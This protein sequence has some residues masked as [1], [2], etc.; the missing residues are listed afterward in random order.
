[1]DEIEEQL[2]QIVTEACRHLPGSTERQRNLTQIIRLTSNKLRKENTPYYEDALQ[3]TW[4]YFCR[5]ICERNTGEP[6]DP[7]RGCVVTW[8]NAYLKWRLRDFFI[9]GHKQQA[10]TFVR[11]VRMW[12][13]GETYETVDLVESL[14]AN[15]DVPSLLEDV[16]VWVET[17]PDGE[18]RSIYIRGRPEVTCQALILRRLPPETSWK[19][20]AADFGISVS[21]LISFYQRQCM[22]RLR[23]F[24]ESEGYL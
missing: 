8:L 20:L 10:K 19:T 12:K 24:G 1:M 23:Q 22:P 13:S 15:P 6:Y 9:D 2:H 16:R 5:N 17:D 11:Q 3:Q 18:L 4:M 14:E 21:T 7:T